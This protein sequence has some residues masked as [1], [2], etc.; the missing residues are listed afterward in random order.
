MG[1][2]ILDEKV[3]E[4]KDSNQPQA[5]NKANKKKWISSMLVALVILALIGIIVYLLFFKDKEKNSRETVVTKENIDEV[6]EQIDKPVLAGQYEVMMTMEWKFKDGTSNA[7][8]ENSTSNTHTVYFDVSLKDTGEV[9]YS[10]PF[11]PI[12]EKIQEFE[13]DKQLEVGEYEAIVTYHLVDESE[14]ELSTTSVN[15]KLI[16][17]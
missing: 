13:L 12:G 5:V 11:V 6:V 10:S 17:E 2:R 3:A 14:E 9:V 15:V 7:Y 1:K 8:V 16:I 4:G